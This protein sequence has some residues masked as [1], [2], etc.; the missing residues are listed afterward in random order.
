MGLFD[1]LGGEL[2]DI[3]EWTDATNNTL[4]HRFERY[5]NEIK[6]GAQLIVRESQCAVFINQGQ[7]IDVFEPGDYVLQTENLPLLST[8][9]G[10]AHGFRSP[11]KAEVY[12]VS[13]RRFTD[14]KWGTSNPITLRDPEFGPVRLRAYGS[15]VIRI[16]D[17]ARFIKEV[18]G[19]DGHFS[20]NEISEQLRNLIVS[21][22]A[23]LLGESKIPV[24]DL[25]AN[26]DELGEFVTQR[27]QADFLEYGIDLKK[28]LVENISLPSVVEQALD[29]RTSMGMIGNLQHYMQYQSANALE[30]AAGNPGG[31]AAAGIGMGMGFAMAEQMAGRLSPQNN[32]A[33]TS[34]SPPPLPQQAVF[35]IALNGQAQGPFDIPRLQQYVKDG[36]LH[37]DTLVWKEGMAQWSKAA[38]LSELS[39]LFAAVPPPLPPQ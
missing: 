33:T 38:E 30:T 12:F 36:Q 39:A 24:L 29:K 16:A 34:A 8:L 21:R 14:L 37:R 2:I 3:V 31:T 4:V 7:L 13:T 5:E 19:T 18:V 25:A 15:Y 35:H 9:E 26:Y 32:T 10:W 11:F 28:M 22:F 20:T 6:M 1:K 17:P 23:D 27:I